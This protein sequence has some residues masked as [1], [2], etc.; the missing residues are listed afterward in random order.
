MSLLQDRSQEVTR[1]CPYVLV[2]GIDGWCTFE[3]FDILVSLYC[4]V[5]PLHIIKLQ[6]HMFSHYKATIFT[7]CGHRNGNNHIRIYLD[8]LAKT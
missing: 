3:G 1:A 5:E 2:P 7:R 8:E 6:F 4:L